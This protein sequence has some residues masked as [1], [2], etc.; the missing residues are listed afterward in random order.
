MSPNIKSN[1]SKDGASAIIKKGAQYPN[2]MHTCAC[3]YPYP[4]VA[5]G[6]KGL[7]RVAIQALYVVMDST[8]DTTV[9]ID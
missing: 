7:H 8:P 1:E 6:C 5:S 2:A 3:V 9:L 4:I